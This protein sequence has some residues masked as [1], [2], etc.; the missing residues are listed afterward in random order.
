M[1][2]GPKYGQNFIQTR[3]LAKRGLFIRTTL[4][5]VRSKRFRADFFKN[6]RPMRKINPLFFIQN[7]LRLHIYRL[8]CGRTVSEKLPK[9]PLFGSF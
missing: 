4:Y 2:C 7:K 3:V 1:L 5:T 9:I 6:R 8:L